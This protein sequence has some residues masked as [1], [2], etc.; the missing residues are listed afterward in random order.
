[1]T[2]PTS[3]AGPPAEITHLVRERTEARLRRDWPRADALKAQIE[4]AG[5]R[6]TDHGS[7]TSVGPA[8]PVSINVHGDP[9]YGSAAAVPSLLDAPATAA[10]TV[11]VPAS[12]EPERL[13][14]LLSALRSHAPA[15]TQI[16]LVANDPS[17]AQAAALWVEAFD[18]SPIGGAVPEVLRTSE[19]LGYAAALNIGLRRT[20]GEFVLLANATAWPSG[21][22]LSPLAAA[23]RD[24]AIAVAGGFGLAAAG[25][26]PLRPNALSRIEAGPPPGATPSEAADATALEGAW[27]AFRRSDY[28]E[29]GPLDERFVTPA[30]LDVWWTLRLRAG[31]EPEGAEYVEPDGE[32]GGEGQPGA[33]PSADRAAAPGAEMPEPAELEFDLPA[34]RRAVRLELPLE[35]EEVSWPPDRSRLNRRNMYR[36]LDRFGWRD[37]LA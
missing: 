30:W 15:G 35:R 29:L 37:D 24:P 13:S 5:W 21:D 4:A 28:V 27:L 32:G 1:M 2:D 25:P 20:A 18:R 3:P 19:R 11:V 26:G 14:R 34:P 16:V 8:A 17:E 9:R 33:T 12:E 6:V 31:A 23:L 36:V 22:A 10:W 7:R